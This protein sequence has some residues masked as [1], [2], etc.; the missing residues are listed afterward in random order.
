MAAV[1]ASHPVV[2]LGAG[3]AGLTAALTLARA[4]IAV[5]LIEAAA[6]AGGR[7]RSLNRDGAE[8]DN[9]QHV[10]VGACHA[11]LEQLRSVGTDPERAFAALPFG[12]RMHAPGRPHPAFGLEPRS[13]RLPALARGLWQSL[14][15]TA[16]HR[17]LPALLGAASIL[18][19][20][21]DEDLD[22]LEWLQARHQPDTLIRQL[23]EPLCLAV[24]NT[25]TRSASAQ[26]FQ[27]V[28]RLALNHGPDDARLLI[29]TRPLGS[30]YPEPALRELRERGATIETGRRIVAIESGGTE[31]RYQL[32]DRNHRVTHANA[33][34]LATAPSAAARLL[35]EAPE[36][37][38][39]HRALVAMGE[40][41]ICTV[42]LRY[43]GPI[44]ERPPL[45]GLIDQHGQW[46]IP[47]R[48][49]GEPHWLAVVISTADDLPA[50]TAE[51]RWR[52]VAEELERTFPELG[53]P[54][55]GHVV[56]ERRATIDA[57]VDLDALRPVAGTP[58]PGLFLAGDYVTPGL[59]ST[60][61]AA[62]RS[63]LESAHKLLETLP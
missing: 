17:R 62:V 40:R 12:L 19:R 24:M 51:E 5:H 35:P 56:C 54:Q 55:T 63:G 16:L 45:Q 50:M 37:Q 48:V 14:A 42:Y 32:R 29:P 18:H 31:A 20:P 28:L 34:I 39:H 61:E 10:L 46:L 47:R 2:V 27:N 7:A 11:T 6:T 26:I 57:R 30:L 49:A 3:W 13:P 44:L 53:I 22:V 1:P 41:S 15:G 4:G 21:L 23:W 33:V 8:L 58:W 36:L 25:P 60:L 59:P 38:P 9:G 43:P 52:R